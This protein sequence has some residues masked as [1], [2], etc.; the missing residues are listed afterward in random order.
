MIVPGVEAGTS[1]Y[2][3]AVLN[4]RIWA[5][6]HDHGISG[7]LGRV[8]AFLRSRLPSVR[9]LQVFAQ[10]ASEYGCPGFPET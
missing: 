1:T 10:F 6:M 7:S 4:A 8:S 5:R 9:N 2:R 3:A